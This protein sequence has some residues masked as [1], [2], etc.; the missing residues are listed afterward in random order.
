MANNRRPQLVPPE[1]LDPKLPKGTFSYSQYGLYQRC[2]KAYEFAYIKNLKLPPAGPQYKGIV[3]HRG[4][5]EAHRAV[6]L[7]GAVPKLAQSQAVVADAFEEGKEEVAS[8]D[9][10]INEGR[11]KD[12]AIRGYT[13]YHLSALPKVNPVAAEQPFVFYLDSMPVT[14]YIDLIDR[15]VERIEGTDVDDP[16]TLIVADLKVSKASWSQADLDKDPQFTLYSRVTGITTVRVDNLVQLKNGPEFKQKTAKRDGR[17]HLILLEHM[18]ETAALIKAGVFPKTS[19]DHWS[20]S[21]NF[22]GYWKLC[23]GRKM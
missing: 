16:G 21:E 20:C 6:I 4:V 10:D 9:D 22:C 19:I 14:G 15:K 5:E 23:R 7:N 8:W 17:T 18:A 11:A 13:A 1:K 2:P 12:A 3:I